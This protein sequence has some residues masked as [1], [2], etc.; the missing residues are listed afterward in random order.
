MAVHTGTRV[1]QITQS[2]CDW[3]GGVNSCTLWQK[4]YIRTQG[5]LE[6]YLRLATVVKVLEQNY[7]VQSSSSKSS[8]LFIKCC[9]RSRSPTSMLPLTLPTV[10][11]PL[12]TFLKFMTFP[13]E[14]CTA[15]TPSLGEFYHT[16]LE[17]HPHSNC[18]S[19]Y[20]GI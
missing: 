19:L 12:Y 13:H 1:D 11:S 14:A 9:Y 18:K 16:L 2:Q 10:Q 20:Y 4:L 8:G 6:A 17:F 15:P 7:A 3:N 5:A